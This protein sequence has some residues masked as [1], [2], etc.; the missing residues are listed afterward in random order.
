M[1]KN[2]TVTAN[3]RMK[4]ERPKSEVYEMELEGLI[5]ASGEAST[6]DYEDGGEL[7]YLSAPG[8]N[9]VNNA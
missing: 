8:N 1:T 4:Y 9:I 3:Q 2:D 5:A 6:R 7:S